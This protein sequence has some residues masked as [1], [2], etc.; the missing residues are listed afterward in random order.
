MD[1]FPLHAAA[2]VG[3]HERLRSL[4]SL[5]VKVKSDLSDDDSDSDEEFESSNKS[6]KEMINKRDGR[7]LS[8]L[9]IAVLRGHVEAAKVLVSE[10]AL[11]S[12]CSV[13]KR[14]IRPLHFCVLCI[15]SPEES[16]RNS[17]APLLK[18]FLGT[19]SDV[20]PLETDRRKRTVFH[21]SAL[22]GATACLDFLASHVKEIPQDPDFFSEPLLPLALSQ[23]G[24]F[25]LWFFLSSFF[26]LV[27]CVFFVTS[28][29]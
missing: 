21:L 6:W 25:F 5:T 27:F 29:F 24:I 15:L 23:K 1:L 19:D 11:I 4:L 10:G 18:L 16:I 12:R 7:G 20:D 3:D 8:S 28:P 22:Y 9:Q 14:I 2:A 17:S 26:F 13:K